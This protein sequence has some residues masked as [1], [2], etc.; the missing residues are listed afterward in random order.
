MCRRFQRYM[1]HP[2][3]L[4]KPIEQQQWGLISTA[5]LGAAQVPDI[6]HKVFVETCV[7]LRALHLAVDAFIFLAHRTA[8]LSL[9][10]DVY[11]EAAHSNVEHDALPIVHEHMMKYGPRSPTHSYQHDYWAYRTHQ[12]SHM[13]GVSSGP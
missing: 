11:I 2:V 4:D 13:Q 8:L 6:D 3:T 7:R 9:P 10:Q 5:L 12:A 1:P